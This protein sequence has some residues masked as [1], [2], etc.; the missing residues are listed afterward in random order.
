MFQQESAVSVKRINKFIEMTVEIGFVIRWKII[1]I[2]MG[3]GP[4]PKKAN[5]EKK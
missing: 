3:C 4:A 5:T 2:V 1:T